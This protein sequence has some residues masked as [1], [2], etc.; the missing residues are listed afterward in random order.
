MSP[1]VTF[2]IDFNAIRIA[3]IA[4][5]KRVTAIECI[6]SEPETQDAPRPARPY[7]TM[8]I[9]VAAGR[10]ADD[11]TQ[12]SNTGVTN[13]GGQRRMSV[14]FQCFATSHEEAYNYM[15]LWQSC[16]DLFTTQEQ[17]R[18][19]GIAVWTIQNVADISQLLNT[20]YEGRSQLDCTFGIASNLT[21]DLSY[22]H[23]VKGSGTITKD[24][25]ET[26]TEPIDVSDT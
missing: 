22:V 13:R 24:S 4:E 1:P 8:K 6:E 11:S 12:Y 5:M 18:K 14:S 7:F 16:L 23:E 26:E 10:S 19:A 25:G 9:M 17:L 2:P 15:A 20:G 21:E 3:M